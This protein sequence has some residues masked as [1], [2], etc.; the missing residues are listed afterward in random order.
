[1]PD[2]V[3]AVIEFDGRGQSRD[4]NKEFI[5]TLILTGFRRAECESIAWSAVDLR[6]GFI[7]SID[8]KNGEVHSLPMGDV[9][10]AIMKNATANAL[11]IGCL[12]LPNQRA[13][14]LKISLKCVKNQCPM[15]YSIHIPRLTADIRLNR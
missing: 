2:W 13:D 1:M 5:L 11:M 7:T 3:R 10:W 6:Y 9:L 8:P 14:I 12:N 15:R 4:T